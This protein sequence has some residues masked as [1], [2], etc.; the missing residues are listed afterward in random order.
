MGGL[1][2]LFVLAYRG[3]TKGN[4]GCDGEEDLSRADDDLSPV[5]QAKMPDVL[6]RPQG[7]DSPTEQKPLPF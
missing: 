2:P 4:A 5:T 1:Q 3:N 6:R 7:D